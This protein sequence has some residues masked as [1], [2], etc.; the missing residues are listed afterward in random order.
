MAA[1]A[2]F[3]I[4][5]ASGEPTEPDEDAAKREKGRSSLSLPCSQHPVFFFLI[6]SNP[7]TSRAFAH[8]SNSR[9]TPFHPLRSF[10]PLRDLLFA[11]LREEWASSPVTA[12]LDNFL[13]PA[14]PSIKICGVTTPS[15]AAHLADLGVHAL[16]VNFW[17]PSKRYCSLE[18]AQEFLPALKGRI[19][20]VGV[21]VNADPELPRE[22]LENDLLDLVQFHGDEN[23]AY[24]HQFALQELPFIK[25]ISIPPDLDSVLALPPPGDFETNAILIDA[26]APGVYGGTG[27]TTDWGLCH[28]YSCTFG[29]LSIILAGG[30]TPHN[31]AQALATVQPAALDIASGAESEPGL[32]DFGK[33]AALLAAVQ[34]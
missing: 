8:T 18:T 26:H 21:F 6:D 16:G 12:L 23:Q 4:G 34:S 13:N 27:E 14:S 31:A 22:L 19:L 33:V 2:L 29:G 20:R 15:D 25:A 7:A 24:C 3:P 30:I 11:A 5:K 32:K 17:E 10:L 9:P 28:D 1:R